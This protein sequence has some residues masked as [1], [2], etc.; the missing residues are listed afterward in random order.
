MRLS[1]REQ[2]EL[3]DIER[4]LACDDPRFAQQFTPVPQPP[5]NR[6]RRWRGVFRRP[7]RQPG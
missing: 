4:A 3:A 2:Q 7:R 1:V 6:R 5:S